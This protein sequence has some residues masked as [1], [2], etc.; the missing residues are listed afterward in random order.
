[1]AEEFA[2][3]DGLLFYENRWVIPNDS[4]LRLRILNENHDSKVAGHFG[5]FKTT[6]RMK[7]NFYWS[8]MDEEVRDYVRSCD[9]CQRDKVRRME[10]RQS[11]R[12]L[13]VIFAK[14]IWRLHGLLSD[15]VSDRDRRFTPPFWR[16]LTKHL[17]IKLAMSTAFLPQTDRQTERVNETFSRRRS[18]PIPSIVGV[19]A[20][21]VAEISDDTTTTRT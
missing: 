20:T 7:Q 19:S 5:Q 1:V 8:K 6:E 9:T 10:N 13:V 12:D 14:E 3:K 2:V 18:T 4:A 21:I 15:I 16:E 11:A 17:G